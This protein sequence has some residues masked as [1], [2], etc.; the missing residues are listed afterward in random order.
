[1][2]RDRQNELFIRRETAL[3]YPCSMRHRVFALAV[4]MALWP[5]SL[6]TAQSNSALKDCTSQPGFPL[7][8]MRVLVM[9]QELRAVDDLQATD[10]VL[11]Q[12]SVLQGICASDRVRQPISV[13]ILSGYKREHARH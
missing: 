8:A 2:R 6:A 13:G 10:F 12:N 7:L 3:R 11:K 5:N 4:A 9:T 1:M